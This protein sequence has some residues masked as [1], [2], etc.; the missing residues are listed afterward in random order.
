MR[1][2]QKRNRTGDVPRRQSK[3]TSCRRRSRMRSTTRF[4]TRRRVV[5]PR[6][7][8]V[9]CGSCSVRK[10]HD[11]E[12]RCCVGVWMGMGPLKELFKSR[13]KKHRAMRK[14]LRAARALG[15]KLDAAQLAG[16]AAAHFE[17]GPHRPGALM[18]QSAALRSGRAADTL[19]GDSAAATVTSPAAATWNN[20]PHSLCPCVLS[21]EAG[22]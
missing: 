7:H 6:S 21:A 15:L 22:R 10:K 19:A 11:C 3:R 1:R 16:G 9:A 17:T 4:C 5:T 8:T 12:S 2:D 13:S 18:A 20:P 14:R